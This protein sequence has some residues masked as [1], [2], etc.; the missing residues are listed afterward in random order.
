MCSDTFF[1][2]IQVQFEL[3]CLL[4]N[5]NSRVSVDCVK[6]LYFARLVDECSEYYTAEF[7]HDEFS[8]F[9]NGANGSY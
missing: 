6:A 2:R 9:G 4:F 3:V 7:V 5:Q 8:F 1:T